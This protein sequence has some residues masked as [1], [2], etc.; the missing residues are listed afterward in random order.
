MASLQISKFLCIIFVQIC[1]ASYAIILCIVFIKYISFGKSLRFKKNFIQV[2][3][4]L[5]NLNIRYSNFCWSLKINQSSFVNINKR[6][7]GHIAHLSH[8]GS[9]EDSLNLSVYYY[10][11]AIIF[12]WKRPIIMILITLNSLHPRMLLSKFG[13]NWPS[14][15]WEEEF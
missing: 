9:G 12:P 4:G 1:P 3:R 14:G 6:P 15:S 11:F 8:I 2:S 7:M 13:W 10:I 5:M